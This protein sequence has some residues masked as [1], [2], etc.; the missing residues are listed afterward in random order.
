VQPVEFNEFYDGSGSD[1]QFLRNWPVQSVVSVTVGGVALPL[2]TPGSTNGVG[3]VIDGSK[4]SISMR[5]GSRIPTRGYAGSYSRGN[6]CSGNVGR[7]FRGQQNVNVDYIAGFPLAPVV[8]E[9]QTI[10]AGS[11]YLV[12]P[13]GQWISDVGVSLF[14]GGT[15]LVKSN[16]SPNTGQYFVTPQGLYMFNAAQAGDQILMNYNAAGTPGDLQGF[17]TRNI[18]L[19]LKRGQWQGQSSQSMAG[20][21]G[22][23]NY[24]SAEFSDHDKRILEIYRRTAAV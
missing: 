7:F 6:D 15:P 13:N 9:L 20:G 18:S 17:A 1:R 2:A 10:P 5:G 16:S 21:A 14:V 3:I 12:T 19:V 22:T 4:K 24:N 23:I 11:P 8:A